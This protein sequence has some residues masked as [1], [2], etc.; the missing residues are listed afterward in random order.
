LAKIRWIKKEDGRREAFDK[1]KIADAIRRAQRVLNREDSFVAEELASVVNLFLE[2]NF[3]QMIPS[4]EDID[5]M[6][7]RVLTGTGHADV[8]EVYAGQRQRRA[9]RREEL[10][11][12][13]RPDF[14][15]L[16]V[17]PGRERKAEAWSKSKIIDALVKEAR[18]DRDLAAEIADDV[19]DR[20]FRSGLR[21]IS[22][23]LVREL[24]DNELF[25][26]GFR[27]QLQKQS[28]VG[29]P[30]FDLK[31]LI[32]MGGRGGSPL[33]PELVDRK[34][35]ES[36]L[37]QFAYEEI[38]PPKVADAHRAGVIHIQDL[39][40][41]H[42]LHSG[43]FLLEGL[44]R[45]PKGGGGEK[46]DG[47]GGNVSPDVRTR[48]L[49]PV[50]AF[51]HS[52]KNYYSRI[53]GLPF[54]NFFLAPFTFSGED[55]C[56]SLALLLTLPR[57]LRDADGADSHPE[58][59]FGLHTRI[60]DWLAE[61]P[62]PFPA[63]GRK[64]FG[65]CHDQAIRLIERFLAYYAEEGGVGGRSD[66]PRLTL[67][68]HRGSLEDP[69]KEAIFGTAV[70]AAQA[71]GKIDMI[72]VAKGLRLPMSSGFCYE[73]EV[74]PGSP[75]GGSARCVLGN[76]ILNLP[77]AAY[78]AGRGRL[79][80][81]FPELEHAIDR[82]ILALHHKDRFLSSYL[83]K[84]DLPLWSG[85]KERA[86]RYALA[87]PE[88]LTTLLTPVGLNECVSFLTGEEMWENREV[89]R[90][91]LRV[92]AHIRKT[93]VKAARQIG[94]RLYVEAHPCEKAERR[95][96]LMDV[97]NHPEA[98]D[99][100]GEGISREQYRYSGGTMPGRTFPGSFQE[101]WNLRIRLCRALKIA[102]TL[103]WGGEA[104]PRGPESSELHALWKNLT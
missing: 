65:D 83:F 49:C 21:R 8:A 50:G 38:Y 87:E 63:P 70:R 30:K 62:T 6:V 68:V 81:L 69:E 32:Y 51:F 37:R 43:A 67:I 89:E 40:E 3:T 85:N 1:S 64:R 96:A 74:P 84:P 101:Y 75:P 23:A 11:V 12:L 82:A 46:A 44:L 66:L 57:I 42:R 22:T 29:I 18:I 54:V 71:T 94:L 80:A 86:G 52:A 55:P 88:G 100:F 2:K 27:A 99:L 26:R 61:W 93:A 9:L 79:E 7:E 34:I 41:P 25:E 45:G 73:N 35:S 33:A 97:D 78:R 60:P 95:L 90:L 102:P 91:A 13:K 72:F 19:E 58:I 16:L 56:D 14:Q 76:V 47:K 77:Q 53:I 20:V 24:V 17:N 4:L 92:L 98:R 39:V 48:L 10:R 36:V 15:D 5:E 28:L 104:F 103:R 31:K 59:T